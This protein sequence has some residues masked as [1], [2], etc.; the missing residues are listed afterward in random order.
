MEDLILLVQKTYG[1]IGLILFSPVAATVF[2]WIENKSL[3]RLLVSN[4]EAAHDKLAG[5]QA[6]RVDDAKA[7]MEKL[8]L[9]VSQQSSINEETNCA[10][11]RIEER[12]G[13]QLA[14]KG[15]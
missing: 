6:H 1:L 3:T 14:K 12:I 5:V 13:K 4:T 9:I 11:E 10:L 8:M 15:P 2:L 7:I